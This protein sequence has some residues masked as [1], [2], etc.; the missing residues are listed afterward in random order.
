MSGV[1]RYEWT[2]KGM[3][4]HAPPM[5]RYVEASHLDAAQ[6][7]LAALRE[8]LD[9]KQSSAE[10]F[11]QK[12]RLAETKQANAERKLAAVEQRNATMAAV[13]EMVRGNGGAMEEFEWD[14]IDAAL[15]NPTES[16]VSNKCACIRQPQEPQC[17]DCPNRKSGASE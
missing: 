8:A 12:Q 4:Q 16:G 9:E 2:A 6:S 14:R 10:M 17:T 7:E 5:G 13:L 3:R 11:Y 15:A 1:M